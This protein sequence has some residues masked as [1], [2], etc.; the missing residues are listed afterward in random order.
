MRQ[1]GCASTPKRKPRDLYSTRH[2][3][4]DPT[5]TT[6]S[7][8]IGDDPLRENDRLAMKLKQA[9]QVTSSRQV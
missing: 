8:V 7:A 5:R 6:Q 1:R 4:H 2:F 9:V 3:R